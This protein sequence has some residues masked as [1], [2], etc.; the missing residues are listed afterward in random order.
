MTDPRS[1]IFEP[2]RIAALWG[3]LLLAPAA[4][5]TNLQVGYLLVHPACLKNDMSLLH[6]VQILCLIAALAGALIA[7]RVWRKE[8]PGFPGEAGSRGE[9]SRFMARI[10]VWMSALFALVIVSQAVPSFMLDQCQ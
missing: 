10:G 5:A 2:K 1:R 3:G 4:F 9:R 7:W 8:G 6:L